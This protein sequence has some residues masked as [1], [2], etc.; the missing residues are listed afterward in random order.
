MFHY[1][2]KLVRRIE[3]EDR[4]DYL[5]T[6]GVEKPKKKKIKFTGRLGKPSRPVGR[7]FPQPQRSDGSVHRESGRPGRPGVHP[8]PPVPDRSID[9]KSPEFKGDDDDKQE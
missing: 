8:A 4:R 3:E 6:F 1:T 7:P 9:N 5:E 2:K